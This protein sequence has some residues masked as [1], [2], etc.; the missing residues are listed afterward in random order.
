MIDYEKRARELEKLIRDVVNDLQESSTI[1]LP[2]ERLSY[3][4]MAASLETC[5]EAILEDD[6][7]PH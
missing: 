2:P 3:L 6:H 5:L 1:M 4:I 7:V